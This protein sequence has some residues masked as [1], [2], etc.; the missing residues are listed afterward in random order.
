MAIAGK[1][2]SDAAL[3]SHC[4][5]LAALALVPAACRQQPQGAL[6]VV[7]IGGEPEAARPGARAA[8]AS[9]RGAARECRAGPRPVR[10]QRQYRRR[11]RRALERQR[12]RAELH[13]PASRRR[14]GPTARKIT[15]RA[16]RASCSSA[17]LG[18]A[19]PQPAQGFAR[20]GRR[21][22]RDD[23]PG[24]RNP[25]AR[26]AAQPARAPRPAG[27]RDPPRQRRHRP[28]HAPCRTGGAGRRAA[29]DARD[30]STAT[31]SKPQH[32]EVLL[33]R[34]GRA[35][36][37][38]RAFAAGKTDLVLGGTF[39]D[40]PLRAA[41]KLPARR[42]AVRSRLGPVRAGAGPCRRAARQARGAPAAQRRRSI[43]T[44]S[45]ARSAFPGLAPRATL[46]EPGL[47]GMPAPVAPHWFATPLGD[48]LPALRAQADRLF[49][50]TKPADR[51]RAARRARAPTCCSQR[52][53]SATGARSASPSSR[54]RSPAAADFALIDEVAPS[55]SPAWF[56][57]RFRCGVV[58]GLRRRRPTS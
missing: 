51:S 44:V 31:T 38:S 29:P 17:Q 19:Q 32:E 2:R 53:D 57:R 1:R 41:C 58:A 30:R 55:S 48:R 23:R 50:K 4:C 49:G 25:A 10:R 16:G 21:H 12:R 39:A 28:V 20:R 40:L 36:R 6:K 15:A 11:P 47:D 7:V 26:A 5:S 27:A 9:R 13:L 14:N 56:V 34:R 8:S 33:A 18:D 42:A 52:A 43:A 45:S 54:R 3:R 22:R 35:A 46:L 37:R 24:D